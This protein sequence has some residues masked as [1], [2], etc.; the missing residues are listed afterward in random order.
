MCAGDA[1][2]ILWF[3]LRVSID[4][5]LVVNALKHGYGGLIHMKQLLQS[6]DWIESDFELVLLD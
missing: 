3:E 1:I 2:C 5:S 4:L 6:S